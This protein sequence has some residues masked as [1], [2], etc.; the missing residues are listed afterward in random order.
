MKYNIQ[1]NISKDKEIES[2]SDEYFPSES[3]ISS[4]ENN[5]NYSKNFSSL[6]INNINLNE[7]VN[8]ENI[9]VK[10]IRQPSLNYISHIKKDDKNLKSLS[11]SLT[12]NF[13]SIEDDYYDS[14]SLS[15]SSQNSSMKINNSFILSHPTINMQKPKEI[16]N[17]IMMAEK[18]NKNDY[19]IDEMFG[20]LKISEWV[21]SFFTVMTIILSLVYQDINSDMKKNIN[22]EPELNKIFLNF[23]LIVTSFSVICFIF[24]TVLRYIIQIKLFKS[25]NKISKRTTFFNFYYF[26]SFLIEAFLSLFHPNI[27]TKNIIIS[28]KKDLY[29]A[30]GE[31]ELNDMLTFI[32][33]F[34][35]YVIFRWSIFLTEFYTPRA[36]RISHLIGTQLTKG[37]ALRCFILDK[38]FTFLSL[39]GSIIILLISF[40]L[41]IL[42]GPYYTSDMGI[43]DY[44]KIKNCIWNVL[45]TMTTVGYGDMYPTTLFGKIIIIFF[46]LI[47]VFIVSLVALAIQNILTLKKYEEN[48]FSLRHDEIIEEKMKKKA[49]NFFTNSIKYFIVSKNYNKIIAPNKNKKKKNLKA[50]FEESLY[51][52][53]TSEKKFKSF[54][55]FY[56]NSQTINEKEL[57]NEKMDEFER[58]LNE[59]NDI[60][61]EI[62]NKIDELN[63]SIFEKFKHQ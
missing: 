11:Q 12:S 36:Y 22:S 2:I 10:K 40:M 63:N 6:N 42:E 62:K 51:N 53:I 9:N 4:I 14:S 30:E 21:T 38:P 35:I 34:R 27:F 32:C 46:C 45:V 16:Y 54:M 25:M 61:K 5:K 48:S 49:A 8:I 1:T 47:G 17:K 28:T 43:N 57:L 39:F 33:L 7:S 20:K 19:E 24:S 18:E 56:K 41:K 29:K 44:R 31:Y 13:S 52:K 37:F 3:N 60:N 58:D 23:I 50:E 59:I 15:T 55:Q 26:S